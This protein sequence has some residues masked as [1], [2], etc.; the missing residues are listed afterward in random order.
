MKRKQLLVLLGVGLMFLI[1]IFVFFSRKN[2]SNFTIVNTSP[3][4]KTTNAST[5]SP[6]VIMFSKRLYADAPYEQIKITPQLDGKT[7]VSDN[8]IIFTPVGQLKAKTT[9]IVE[10]V[11]AST[12][13]ALI[14]SSSFSF[15]TGSQKISSFELTLPITEDN[16]TIDRLENGQILVIINGAPAGEVRKNVFD[17]LRKKGVD[18]SS[19][20]VQE[21]T[22]SRE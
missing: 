18:T 4:D 19:V 21:S 2:F 12:N 7:T 10:V 16:Y 22:S 5:T 6:I 17:L 9:Y 14:E 3:K 8:K 13:N 15:T 20:L 1:L 11:G